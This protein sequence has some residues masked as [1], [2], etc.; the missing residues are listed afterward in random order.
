VADIKGGR[1]MQEQGQQPNLFELAG[2]D[3]H[4][5]YSTTS[6]TGE[7]QFHYQG[8]LGVTTF[9]GDQI[10]TSDSALGKLVTVQLGSWRLDPIGRVRSLAFTVLL[11]K[12]QLIDAAPQHF[13]TLGISTTERSSL[14][15]VK[16]PI[17]GSVPTYQVEELEGTAQ[18]VAF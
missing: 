9:R 2:R 4:V 3:V 15:D 1:I 11:P 5:T 7:A 13:R 16:S 18:L 6:F 10:M 17:T 14:P 8:P 12:F